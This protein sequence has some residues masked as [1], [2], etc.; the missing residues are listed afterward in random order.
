MPAPNLNTR[1]LNLRQLRQADAPALHIALGDENVM[2]W[3]SSPPHQSLAETEAY[4][5]TNAALSDGWVCWAITAAADDEALG[6][7]VLIRKRPDVWEVGYILRRSAWGEG[8]G[9]EALGAVLNHAFATMGSR[10]IFA[11]TDPENAASIK[12]LKSLG[13][14]EEGHLRGEWETHIGVRDSL[15]FGLLR[16]EWSRLKR[17]GSRTTL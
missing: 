16:D 2:T 15:I 3:W 14:V 8:Y 7:V 4:V 10:R 9:R 6:W 13:F 12:L 17:S 1:R 5:A 11:D